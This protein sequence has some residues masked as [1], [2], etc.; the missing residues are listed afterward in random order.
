[1]NGPGVVSEQ[2]G[3]KREALAELLRKKRAK[4][5][6]VRPVSFSQRRVWF[7]DQL[8]PGT[9]SYNIHFVAPF[10]A[11]LDQEVLERS[12][13]A[14]IQR[15]E[16]LRTTFSSQDGEPMQMISPVSNV[17]VRKMDLRGFSA[18]QQEVE[19]SR[20]TAEQVHQPFDLARGPL[21]RVTLVRT[22]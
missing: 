9:T 15:H 12:L 4:E 18:E 17:V 2:A 13:Q 11:E 22:N 16:V 3:S 20:I 5:Q 1:M 19:A 7:L 6:K 21:M 8:A 10:S 14:V